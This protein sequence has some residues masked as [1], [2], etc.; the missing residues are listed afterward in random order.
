MIDQP[1]MSSGI[2]LRKL[3]KI[4]FFQISAIVQRKTS[5]AVLWNCM[6]GDSNGTGASRVLRFKHIIHVLIHEA[7]LWTINPVAAVETRTSGGPPLGTEW[8]RSR[9][10]FCRGWVA[11]YIRKPAHHYILPFS[12]N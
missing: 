3:K 10:D 5:S 9:Q 12:L 4:I 6:Q 7:S 11:D 1:Q 8:W 2:F